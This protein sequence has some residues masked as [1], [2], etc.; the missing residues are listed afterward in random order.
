MVRT[1]TH[2]DTNTVR[3]THTD[4]DT[5]THT[6]TDTDADTDTDTDTDTDSDTDTD[7]STH[8]HTHTTETHTQTQTQ[9]PTQHIAAGAQNHARARKAFDLEDVPLKMKDELFELML[10]QNDLED[11]LAPMA[12]WFIF[13]EVCHQS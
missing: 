3:Q 8:T 9:A 7:T 5:D 12:F 13:F 4:T 2:T 1:Y 6:N 10:R 11:T